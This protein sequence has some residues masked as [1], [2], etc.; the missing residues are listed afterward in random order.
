MRSIFKWDLLF[1]YGFVNLWVLSNTLLSFLSILIAKH[2]VIDLINK[3]I[4]IY[5]FAR[6][7][8]IIIYQIN[9]LLFDKIRSENYKIYSYRRTIILLLH[10]YIEIIFWFSASY[11]ILSNQFR[12]SLNNIPEIIYSSFAIMTT[13]NPSNINPISVQGIYI[14]WFQSISG[15]LITLISISR[16]IGLLPSVQQVIDD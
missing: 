1:T 16:F 12:G 15:I 3:I 13:F 14:I 6:V 4:L 8:E 9:V 2:L 11:I 5:G 10:N 7:F